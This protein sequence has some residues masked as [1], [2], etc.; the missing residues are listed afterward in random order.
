ME[1][2]LK[3]AAYLQI[4]SNILEILYRPRV[5]TDSVTAVSYYEQHLRQRFDSFHAHAYIRSK[6]SISLNSMILLE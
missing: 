1:R 2:D 4:N 5:S 3:Y 6:D